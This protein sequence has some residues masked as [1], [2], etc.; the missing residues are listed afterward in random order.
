MIAEATVVGLKHPKWQERPVAFIVARAD[1][2]ITPDA[3]KEFLAPRIASWWMPD[4][5]VFIDE[6]PKTGTGKFDKKVVREQYADLLTG[7]QVDG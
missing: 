4:E 5:F 3:L 1:A 7:R 6:I 2:D